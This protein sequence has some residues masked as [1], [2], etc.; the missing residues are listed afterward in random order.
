MTPTTVTTTTTHLTM[1][2]ALVHNQKE[3]GADGRC[4]GTVNQRLHHAE[5][6]ALTLRSAVSCG[7]D[8][9]IARSPDNKI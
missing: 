9:Q 3:K 1:S 5:T 8:H 4:F 6:L 2:T 7:P